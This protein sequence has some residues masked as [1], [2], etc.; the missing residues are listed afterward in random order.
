MRTLPLALLLALAAPATV[1]AQT[2][3]FSDVVRKVAPA[4]VNITTEG[5]SLEGIFPLPMPEGMPGMQGQGAGFIV[6]A[7][8]TIVTNNHVVEGVQRIQV[9]MQ[10]GRTYDATLV[11]TDPLTDIAVLDI[12]G[13][14]HPV[15]VFADSDKV[16]VGDWALAL[17]NPLGQGFSVSL[18]IVSAR[19]RMLAGAFDDY[20]QTDAAINRGN[21]GGPL[22]NDRGEVMGMNTAIL[23]PTGGS[24]GIGFAM[25]SNVVKDVTT[26]ITTY[27][28]T[29]RGWLGVQMQEVTP[30][31]A[32]AVGLDAP[33][34]ALVVELL[35][36]PAKDAG[37]LSGDI[38][39]GFDG[40]PV[41]DTADLTRRIAKAGPDVTVEL[42]VWREGARQTL[43]V[44][45]GSR[46]ETQ[47]AMQAKANEPATFEGWTFA[48][49]EDA[50]KSRLNLPNT[51]VGARITD[52]PDTGVLAV[53]DV[54]VS[55]N[56]QPITRAQDAAQALQAL[57]SAGRA[58]ALLQVARGGKPM[59]VVLP[60]NR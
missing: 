52:A 57:K 42:D 48:N 16:E 14:D 43:T 7:N 4:V 37:L 38:V 27:G 53:D 6:G 3:D 21:S 40:N 11:G 15:L 10:D 20:L 18:G 55:I 32:E 31:I 56:Q 54:V 8:G 9:E 2:A 51:V 49:L 46:E 22:F 29:R 44:A 60:L 59:F 58:S 13:D 35:E 41:A 33:K 24:I 17:G 26:Q 50:D 23:S 1:H 5:T 39:L 12:E 30:G 28:T 34:G 47:T 25:S 45:L 36:G 19:G